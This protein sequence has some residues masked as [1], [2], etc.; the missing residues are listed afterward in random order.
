[1]PRAITTWGSTRRPWLQLHLLYRLVLE[2]EALG[3]LDERPR[4]GSVELPNLPRQRD[5]AGGLR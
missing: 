4:D 5:T 2:L 1:M 3:V